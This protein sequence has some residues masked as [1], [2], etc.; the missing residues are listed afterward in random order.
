[1]LFSVC[2]AHGF[3]NLL[4]TLPHGQDYANHL[5]RWRPR[6]GDTWHLDEVFL[7]IN[8]A[9]HYRWRAVDQEDRVLDLLVQSR[10][11]KQVAKKFFR[12]SREGRRGTPARLMSISA[13]TT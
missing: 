7:T 9:R 11:N 1:M 2:S 6:L 8:G 5:R 10:R 3:I 12:K 13:S 4:T